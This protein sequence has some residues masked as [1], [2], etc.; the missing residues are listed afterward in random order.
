MP[1][2]IEHSA[3]YWSGRFH[4]CALLD[5]LV[6]DSAGSPLGQIELLGICSEAEAAVYAVEDFPIMGFLR[7]VPFVAPNPMSEQQDQQVKP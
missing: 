5:Q 6:F 1:E 3:K 2:I 7:A 4:T